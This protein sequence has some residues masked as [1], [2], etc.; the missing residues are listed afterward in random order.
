MFPSEHTRKNLITGDFALA[1]L[2][3]A[4]SF[5]DSEE[6]STTLS[7]FGL[8]LCHHYIWFYVTII[9]SSISVF[10]KKLISMVCLTLSLIPLM[11]FD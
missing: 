2:E 5:A 11:S 3:T 6:V 10:L 4:G 7:L 9:H 8:F 1:V